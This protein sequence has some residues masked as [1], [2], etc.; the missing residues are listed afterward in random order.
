M[1]ITLTEKAAAEIKGIIQQQNMPIEQTRLRVGV[2]GG[3]HHGL[4]YL[5]DL[6]EEPAGNTDQEM[7]SHGI[8][9]VVDQTAVLYLDGT[10]IDFKDEIIGKGFVFRNPN[11][12]SCGCG[13]GG[14]EG[15]CCG[16][17]DGQGGC[18]GGH[19]GGHGGG[20]CCSS[21]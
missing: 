8:R 16:Q 7:D 1:A 17:G 14:G 19:G 2:K 4:S 13:S 9:I 11:M 10:E 15:G 20:G 6:T 21:N 12:S 5:L 18:C 3:G